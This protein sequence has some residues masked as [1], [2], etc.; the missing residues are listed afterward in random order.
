MVQQGMGIQPIILA[1]AQAQAQGAGRKK[2]QES[3]KK[4]EDIL[5]VFIYACVDTY[6]YNSV[7]LHSINSLV[8]IK[9]YVSIT[10]YQ[11]IKFTFLNLSEYRVIFQFVLNVKIKRNYVL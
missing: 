7:A 4:H 3:N 5:F 11:N 6:M 8:F 9:A 1:Q 10:N 2:C